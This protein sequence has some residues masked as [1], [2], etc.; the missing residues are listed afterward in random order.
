MLRV[1]KEGGVS[2]I[3]RKRKRPLLLGCV[4][5]RGRLLRLEEFL[6]KNMKGGDYF[7]HLGGRGGGGGFLFCQGEKLNKLYEG[8]LS[9]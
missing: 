8:N 4:G 3:W 9:H 2:K 1:G 5:G 6:T 7:G